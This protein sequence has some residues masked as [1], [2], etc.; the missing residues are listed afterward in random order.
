MIEIPLVKGK[1][2][3]LIDDE[4]F[5]LISRFKWTRLICNNGNKIY[6]QSSTLPRICMHRLIMG[7]PPHPLVV[8]HRNHDGLDNRRSNLRVIT[9]KQ[10]QAN[11]RSVRNSSSKYLGV[12]WNKKRKKFTAQIGLGNNKVICLGVFDNEIDAA[13][14]YNEKAKIVHGEFAN[15]NVIE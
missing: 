15:L 7:L 8:D 5:D 2:I 1:S 6:V 12:S 4:D 10:N 14:C 3:A 9:K 13:K 11:R